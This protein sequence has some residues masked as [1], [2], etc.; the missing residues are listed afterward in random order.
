MIFFG[1]KA[2]GHHCSV[3]IYIVKPNINNLYKKG[4]LTLINA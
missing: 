1:Y 3:V 2:I 4:N